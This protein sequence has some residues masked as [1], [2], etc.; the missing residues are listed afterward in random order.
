MAR[1]SRGRG[2]RDDRGGRRGRRDRDEGG[3]RRSRRD[4]D[5]GDDDRERAVPRRPSSSSTPFIVM[6]AFLFVGFIIIAVAMSSSKSRRASLRTDRRARPRSPAPDATTRVLPPPP[7]ARAR[8]AAKKQR[9]GGS[10]PAHIT[11]VQRG[12]GGKGTDNRYLTATCGQCDKK[13]VE[14]LDKCPNCAAQIRWQ[15]TV[16]CEFCCKPENLDSTLKEL[17]DKAGFCARCRGTGK[18]PN[19]RAGTDRLPFGMSRGGPNRDAGGGCF[20]CKGSGG[21]NWCEKQG[22]M[23]VPDRFGE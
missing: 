4:R 21:C 7:R 6:G 19:Y 17:K 16:K 22:W 14:R 13:L 8:L 15:K 5:D 3:G 2:G 18:D 23:N 11:F 20:V 12:F 9:R 10:A 1:R